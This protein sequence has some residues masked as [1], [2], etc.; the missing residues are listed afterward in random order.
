MVYGIC[1]KTLFGTDVGI[2]RESHLCIPHGRCGMEPLDSYTCGCDAACEYYDDCC[3][4][5]SSCGLGLFNFTPPTTDPNQIKCVRGDSNY[6]NGY[7]AIATCKNESSVNFEVKGKC[8]NPDI[9]DVISSIIVSDTKDAIY[10]NIFCAIC[11]DVPINEVTA[12]ETTFNCD[13]WNAIQTGSIEPSAK[14]TEIPFEVHQIDVSVSCPNFNSTPPSGKTDSRRHCR[15][16]VTHGCNEFYT[17]QS[18]INACNTGYNA[19]VCIDNVN[20]Y[21]NPHCAICN[22]YPFY[23]CYL[24][25]DIDPTISDLTPLTIIMDF[26][27]Q[28]SMI[29]SSKFGS[30]VTTAVKCATGEVFDPFTNQCLQ[31][32]CNAGFTLHGSR[33][34]APL[35]V[36]D[37]GDGVI[38]IPDETFCLCTLRDHTFVI[39]YQSNDNDTK[40]ANGDDN[41]NDEPF[42][43]FLAEYLDKLGVQYSKTKYQVTGITEFH[44]TE[45]NCQMVLKISN[46]ITGTL[47]NNN[48]TSI[49]YITVQQNCFLKEIPTALQCVDDGLSLTESLNVDNTTRLISNGNSSIH[50]PNEE[51]LLKIVHQIVNETS[52]CSSLSISNCE[53][54]LQVNLTKSAF[55]DKGNG[56][57]V[58]NS[59][60]HVF[61]EHE[62]YYSN[63]SNT[64]IFMC[65]FLNQTGSKTEEIIFFKYSGTL[66]IISVVGTI[67]S[68]I[69]L[70][71][72]IFLRVIISE[73]RTL[74]G[75]IIMNVSIALF[76]SLLLTLIQSNFIQWLNGCR[77]VAAILHYL[78][79]VCFLWMNS[80]AFELF[81]TFRFFRVTSRSVRA[82]HK[83][84]NQ[85]FLYSWGIPA[86]FVGVI[87]AISSCECTGLNVVYGDETVCWIRDEVASFYV[88]GIPLAVILLPNLILF[89]A[90]ITG[91]R[92]SK[93]ASERVI[94]GKSKQTQ[95]MEEM[96]IYIRIST[97]MGLSW[98]FGFLASFL[99]HVVL[100]YIFIILNSLQ[101]FFVFI[102]FN[103]THSVRKMI[104]KNESILTSK[105][106]TKETSLSEK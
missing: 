20:V 41:A 89:V 50:V 6:E 12:W 31:L 93:S 57:L 40:S 39:K 74:P 19:V 52:I 100:W 26:S 79:L 82:Q 98:F 101:G 24:P 8:E 69:G 78:W 87:V 29:V 70:L 77:A 99:G 63:S 105:A 106:K 73:M 49:M 83:T 27:A 22:F 95:L 3:Y 23:L 96:I 90:T 75:K 33:C 97:V 2:C 47:K 72:T 54:C 34:V 9:N 94:K 18:V 88:F 32:T 64:T 11:N 28:N 81:L 59:T 80:I 65:T 76:C 104:K 25:D 66:L 13:I 86:V 17:D 55:I 36:S 91:I 16:R 58:Y 56:S 5:Y 71:I 37:C 85:Y 15:S 14:P 51:Y 92:E 48:Y 67:L 102:A 7:F 42:I 84:F 61:D 1:F 60:G 62:Y 68:L 30:Y 10:R 46:L 53:T 45:I 103:L 44:I 38:Q 35:T 4:D 21:R 43:M